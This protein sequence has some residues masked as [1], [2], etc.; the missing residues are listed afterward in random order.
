VIA[1]ARPVIR[2]ENDRLHCD[3]A[4]AVSWPDG[5]RYWFWKGVQVPREVIEQP[6]LITAERALTERNAEIRRVMI[7]RMG[8]E[9]FIVE[10]HA[11]LVHAHEMGELFSIGVFGDPDGCVNAVRVTCSSTGRKYFLRVPP[12]IKRADDAVAWTFGFET[13]NYRPVVES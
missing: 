12:S 3:Y 10:G 1:V 6:E 5:A 2:I 7:E 9:R 11:R 4:P 13:A 8:V